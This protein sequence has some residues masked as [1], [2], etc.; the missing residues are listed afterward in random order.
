MH[1]HV[2]KSKDTVMHSMQAIGS[3]SVISSSQ[4]FQSYIIQNTTLDSIEQLLVVV[5]IAKA[6]YFLGLVLSAY[7]LFFQETRDSVTSRLEAE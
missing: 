2:P 3:Q 7:T 1:L 6:S 5:T 4:D